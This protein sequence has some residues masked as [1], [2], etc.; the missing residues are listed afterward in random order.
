MRPDG[1]PAGRYRGLDFTG[2]APEG[3]ERHTA[4]LLA[5]C[6]SFLTLDEHALRICRQ[7]GLADDRAPAVRARLVA[8]ADQGLLVTEEAL[9]E[10]CEARPGAEPDAKVA[11]LGVPTSDRPDTLARALRSYMRNARAHGRDVEVAVLDDSR[12]AASRE[13]NRSLLRSL[14]REHG[15][16]ASYSDA[17][18]RAAYAARLARE[19]GADPAVVAFALLRADERQV[20]TGACRNAL[21]LHGVGD[22]LV[23]ADDDTVCRLAPADG[24]DRGL[25]LAAVHTGMEHAYF[26]SHADACAAVRFVDADYFGLFEEVLGRTVADVLRTLPASDP[27]DLD[28][29]RPEFARALQEA[30]CRIAAASLGVVG[31]SGLGS[32]AMHFFTGDRVSR[33]RLFEF[34]GG[35]VRALESQEVVRSTR[36]TTVAETGLCLGIA[37]GLDHRTLLPPFMPVLRN[38]D[39]AF[40]K[41]R[42]AC[43]PDTAMAFLPWMVE[44]APPSVRRSSRDAVLRD[45]GRAS[46]PE[47][48]SWFVRSFD[49]ES[50]GT[51]D[52]G[53]RLAALG[54]HLQEIGERPRPEYEEACRAA[55]ETRL[56]GVVAYVEGFESHCEP[57]PPGWSADLAAYVARL[58]EAGRSPDAVVPADLTR[59]G[60]DRDA[61]LDRGR[62]LLRS[63]GAL[64]GAWPALVEAARTLRA[65]GHRPAPPLG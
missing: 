61:A 63:L 51:R 22:R 4:G 58:Q 44:H 32:T 14:A 64:L 37:L 11:L 12:Q 8:L 45:A 47:F 25:A 16:R 20:T 10:R 13:R 21:L 38:S 53:R 19:S 23:H 59:L 41:I 42:H 2:T 56:R 9:R 17:A 50:A 49:T 35:Y 30:P 43:F 31:D 33:R 18:D 15:L 7:S 6:D 46:Q 65:R 60:L 24:A 36:R 1:P 40:A 55:L 27:V 26:A 39:G 34:P 48:V 62:A 28:G 3:R 54:R 5:R 52:P 57:G 29:V